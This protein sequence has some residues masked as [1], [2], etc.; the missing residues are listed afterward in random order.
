MAPFDLVGARH[1]RRRTRPSSLSSAVADLSLS[2]E[3]SWRSQGVDFDD[4][5]KHWKALEGHSRGFVDH[6]GGFGVRRLWRARRGRLAGHRA[7]PQCTRQAATDDALGSG[8]AGVVADY[9]RVVSC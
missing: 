8:G 4:F 7:H 1:Q 3:R 5:L 2:S 6:A 9:I